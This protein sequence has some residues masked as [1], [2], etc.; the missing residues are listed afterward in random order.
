[1]RYWTRPRPAGPLEDGAEEPC[2]WNPRE[3][4]GRCVRDDRGARRFSGGSHRLPVRP[5]EA[6]RDRVGIRAHPLD[7]TRVCARAGGKPEAWTAA[8]P[9]ELTTITGRELAIPLAS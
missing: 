7:C 8:Y 4:R 1:L 5:V 2:P 3:D 6:G 9:R